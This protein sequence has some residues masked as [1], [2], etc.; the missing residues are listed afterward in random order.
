QFP[1]AVAALAGLNH[2]LPRLPFHVAKAAEVAGTMD[3]ILTAALPGARVHPRPP[4]TQQFQARAPR[5][6]A[7]LA[8]AGLRQAE[9]T[10]VALF[11]KWREPGPAGLAMSEMTIAEAAMDWTPRMVEDALV[12]FL[13]RLKA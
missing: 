1:A 11:D 5:P 13:E 3:Q 7:A 10:G 8:A 2:T 4:H 12:G 9:E 6:A